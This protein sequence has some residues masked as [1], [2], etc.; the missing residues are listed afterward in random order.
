MQTCAPFHARNQAL[1]ENFSPGDDYSDHY[2]LELPTNPM[3]F[4]PDGQQRDEDFDWTSVKLSRMGHAGVTCM[5]CHDPHGLKTKLPTERNELCLQCHASP[6]RVLASGVRAMPIE[7]QAHSHH[8]AGSPGDSCIACHMPTTNYMQRAPRHDHGWLKP[9]P[10]LT[11]ELGIPNACSRCHADRSLDW[12]LA[13]AD[14]WYGAKLDSRQRRRARAVSAA[15]RDLSGAAEGLLVLLAE[16]DIPAWRA[17][18]LALLANCSERDEQATRR[19]A[20]AALRARDPLERAAAIPLLAAQRDAAD[21]IR[22]L[23]A[24]PS[25]LVRLEAE[26]Q[27]SAELPEGSAERRELDTSLHLNLDQPAG[28][29]RLGSDL[30]NRGR[31]SEAE[32]EMRRA[33]SWDT[34]SAGLEDGLGVLLSEP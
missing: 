22:P 11:R 27:L 4:Y 25:R 26:W 19:T 15:Q 9:D 1:T 32:N 2:R 7:P 13:A 31:L 8:A 18:A 6:G 28:R 24:D 14:E 12:A 5:D 3:T 21:L 34:F 17:T 16:E 33:I 10:L 20:V 29:F 23:L 30:A